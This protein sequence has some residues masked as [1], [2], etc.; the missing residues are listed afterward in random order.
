MS[1][2]KANVGNQGCGQSQSRKAMM[3]RFWAA[4]DGSLTILA[5]CLFLLMVM[6]G[7]LA[8][9]LMRYEQTRTTL[10]NTLDRATLASASLTQT[11]DPAEVVA[12][13]F[14]KAGMDKYLKGVTVSEG[15]NFRNVTA[16]AAAETMF[17]RLVDFKPGTTEIVPALAT[18]WE[19]SDDGLTYTF[20]LRDDVKFHTTDYFKPTRSMN[21]DDV[22]WSFQRQLDPKHPWH[23]K[24][25]V[26]YPYFESMGF[27]ELLKSVEKTDDH[28]VVFTLTRPEAPFLAD[29]AM[30][31]TAI[32]SPMAFRR[33]THSGGNKP[34][35]VGPTLRRKFPP[36]AVMSAMFQIRSSADLKFLSC[37]L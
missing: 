26:G 14:T 10:Q 6:M 35:A 23:N 29:V 8:V 37:L 15:V 31:F 27:K 16:D 33:S 25:N 5:L 24:S 19:I 20:H 9:D 1:M 13:Y 17:N 22:L 3:R 21:A 34:S 12:D 36:L 30:P 32:H 7:G 18:S 2:F 11:L 4:Q 28:T